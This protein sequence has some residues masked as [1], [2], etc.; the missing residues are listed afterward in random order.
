M[1]KYKILYI[2]DQNVNLLLFSEVFIDDY[3]VITADSGK[4]GLE[5]VKNEHID[6]IVSDQS[7]PKMTGVE[8]FEQVLKINPEPNRILLT[9][10][11]DLN[12]L[13]EA[14]NRAK[15]YRYV[16]KPWN[17]D[18]LKPILDAAIHDYVLRRQNVELTEKLKLQTIELQESIHLKNELLAQLE[19]SK[20]ELEKSEKKLR[21]IIELSP[22]PIA[23][24]DLEN[25]N[26]LLN[27]QFTKAFGYT[28]QDV[29]TIN[30]WYSKV[31]HD[32]DYR[33]QHIKEWQKELKIAIL[34]KTIMNAI[35]SVVTC[36]NGERKTIQTKATIVG[37]N[38][39]AIF[40]D[41]T[42]I[43]NLEA[44]ISFRILMEEEILK[45]KLAAEAANKA[46]SE[47]IANM[48]HEIRTPMNAILGYAEVLNQEINN[49]AQA[50]YIRSIQT[51]GKH[52]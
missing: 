21:K 32:I 40:S 6:L 28:L 51:S 29:P 49:P 15:I 1:E 45:A 35:E 3:I 2:D 36:K 30:D 7:M 26:T 24:S 50:S 23:I 37:D 13:A 14:V 4:N 42:K 17:R 5:V 48:S 8:F 27:D 52:F 11:N 18:D 46:K 38:Q 43:R 9:A 12:A 16:K 39:V 44:D 25:N 20:D 34:N 33:D 10:F 41:I 31:Y 22:M 47:F 19:E